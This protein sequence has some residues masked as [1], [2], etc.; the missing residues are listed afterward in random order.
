MSKFLEAGD[1]IHTL[2]RYMNTHEGISKKDDTL[3]D[4]LLKSIPLAEMIDE[5]YKKRG[6]DEDGI[7][8]PETLKKLGIEPK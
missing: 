6:F 2:E 4:R 5:Y 8:K 3:P 1:R 7:P